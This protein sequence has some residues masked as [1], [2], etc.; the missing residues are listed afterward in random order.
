MDAY[1]TEAMVN[2]GI[3]LTKLAI[4]GTATAVTNKITTIKNEKDINNIRQVY[5]EVISE[6]IQERDEAVRIAQSYKSELERI[7]ISD[8]DIEHLHNTISR[9]I[10][11]LREMSPAMDNS[12]EVFEK[13]KEL[14]SIDTLKTMQLLG[15][16][17]KAAIGEPLTN[18]CA[19]AIAKFAH[20]HDQNTNSMKSHGR[21]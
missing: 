13:L 18:L 12:F 17:Y 6:L 11:I 2:L 20:K 15:F 21:K 9:L 14:I 4:K 1:T 7:V 3:E 19:N 10:D 8:K 16:N 5:D